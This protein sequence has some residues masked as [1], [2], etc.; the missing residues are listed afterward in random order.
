M[1]AIEL[2][3]SGKNKGRYVALVDDEDYEYL[4]QYRWHIRISYGKIYA[5]SYLGDKKN[6]PIPMHRVIMKTPEDME[7]DHIFHNG[8]DNRK[9]IEKDGILK[10]NLRN[11][12]HI[13]NTR[14]TSARGASKYLGVSFDK[15]MNKNNIRAQICVSG[16]SIGLGYYSTEEE[17]ARAYD[18]AASYYFKEFANLNFKP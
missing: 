12:T 4:S 10:C 8:L 6:L 16:K 11:C 13:E 5:V 17:A 2:S 7:C 9:F 3:Q 1:K 15:R 14:N 18:K